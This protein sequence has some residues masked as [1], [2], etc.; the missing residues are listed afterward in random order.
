MT[1]DH[2]EPVAKLKEMAMNGKGSAMKLYMEHHRDKERRMNLP[3]PELKTPEDRVEA[4]RRILQAVSNGK[5][6]IEQAKDLTGLVSKHE[7]TREK[8]ASN[9]QQTGSTEI[10]VSKL[11]RGWQ[12][13]NQPAEAVD[14]D[15]DDTS[16]L[17][18]GPFDL[19][20]LV[21]KN[22]RF[23]KGSPGLRFAVNQHRDQARQHGSGKNSC[24]QDRR[25]CP[26][27][28]TANSRARMS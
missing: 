9:G 26:R 27:T 25:L 13:G 14:E 2:E 17:N 1:I 28:A 23:R 10:S 19:T 5:I 4:N 16:F 8:V 22:Q 12:A 18:L 21:E 24:P 6:T 20:I 15:E 11:A 3:L 7:Y